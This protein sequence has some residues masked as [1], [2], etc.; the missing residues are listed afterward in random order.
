MRLTSAIA[1]IGTNPSNIV[2]ALNAEKSGM[3]IYAF[4]ILIGLFA[5]ISTYYFKKD[6]FISFAMMFFILFIISIPL[7]IYECST[8]SLLSSK[9]LVMFLVATASFIALIKATNRGE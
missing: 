2:C 9:Y 6:I 1:N 3:L 5:F 4:L 7:V 8:S